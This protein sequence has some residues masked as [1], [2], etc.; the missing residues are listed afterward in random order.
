MNKY[1]QALKGHFT[2]PVKVPYWVALAYA[3]VVFFF[4]FILGLLAK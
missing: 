2:A 3:E 1:I 4:G